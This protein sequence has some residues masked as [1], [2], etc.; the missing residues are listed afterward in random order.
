VLALETIVW[1]LLSSIAFKFYSRRYNAA[2]VRVLLGAGAELDIPGNEG[3]TP[4]HLAAAEGMWNAAAGADHMAVMRAL[5]A[6]GAA[7]VID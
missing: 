4:L 2:V 5:L 6:A 1:T 7:V 3:E